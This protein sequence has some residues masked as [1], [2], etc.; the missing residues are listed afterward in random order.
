MLR[1]HGTADPALVRDAADLVADLPE[2]DEEDPVDAATTRDLRPALGVVEPEEAL[3][4]M[5]AHSP[6][7]L[8]LALRLLRLGGQA[9]SL[10][11]CLTREFD[12][13]RLRPAGPPGAPQHA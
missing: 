5:R 9:P 10:E 3:A 8:K 13:A 6:T 11:A 12:A 1:A 2:P 7:S 4:A